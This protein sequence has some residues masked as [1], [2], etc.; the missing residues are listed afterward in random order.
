MA[1]DSKEA[2]KLLWQHHP[3]QA[4]VT[5]WR[6]DNFDQ[7][8]NVEE[9]LRA[10]WFKADAPLE[11]F[12][13]VSDDE[14]HRQVLRIY[15]DRAIYTQSEDPARYLERVVSQA[16][17]SAFK[18]FVTTAGVKDLGPQLGSC[19]N[20]CSTLEFLAL[21]KD[22]ARRVFGRQAF[23]AW[24]TIETNFD[25]LGRG[26][27]AKIRYTFESEIKG[28]EILYEDAHL[29][30]KDVWQR[31]D[32]IRIFVERQE[33]EEEYKQRVRS[34]DNSD[35]DDEAAYAEEKKS[36]RSLDWRFFCSCIISNSEHLLWLKLQMN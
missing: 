27:G 26:E 4:F 22:E 2:Q 34:N 8:A 7:M 36:K 11:I 31:G 16:E 24:W 3:N 19:H 14:R 9:K 30:V 6:D 32:E 1:E 21:K 28:L 10:E 12:A 29:E 18:D 35:E 15:A 5:G 23:S 17:L 13:L 33:T 20:N 25:I